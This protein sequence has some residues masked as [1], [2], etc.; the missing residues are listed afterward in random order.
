MNFN[1]KS[2]MMVGTCVFALFTGV[3]VM[4]W[5]NNTE[6]M[7]DEQTRGQLYRDVFGDIRDTGDPFFRVKTRGQLYRD[8]FGDIRDTGDPFFR[9]KTRGQ[10]YR[11]V[12]GDIRDTGDVFF[13]IRTRGQLA[14]KLFTDEDFAKKAD[15]IA[16]QKAI[17][18]RNVDAM[19]NCAW[20]LK[21]LELMFGKKDK[22]TTSDMLF[23]AAAKLAVE[24]G[25]SA[26]LKQVIALAP[27]CKKFEEE[28]A[29]KSKTRGINKSVTAFPQLT[30]LPHKD[31]EK[32][33]KGLQP[34][35]QP[36]FGQYICA[37]FRGMSK[38]SADT[39]AMLVNEGRVTMNPQM[40]AMGALELSKYPYNSKLGIKFEP[41]Q[42][43]AE[44]VEL[45]VAQ[46]DKDA[47]NQIAALYGTA[48]FKNAEY[49]KYLQGE[50][51][52]LGENR[53]LKSGSAQ[54][55]PGDFS[56]MNFEKMIRTV[57]YEEAT[58]PMN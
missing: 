46:Q 56:P 53:G 20:D 27:E 9:V 18:A 22:T 52:M 42:I 36:A 57:Y 30:L 11:D 51:A 58:I 5:E 32:A 8:V 38:K 3:N 35:E 40:I 17:M 16:L 4:A 7:F 34:W 37:S 15:V 33:L 41:A 49:T 19:T 10:L 45:A 21:G 2:L 26:A 12:F 43:F 29:L 39:V 6:N 48:N 24:Q 47:L 50:L 31:W 55:K 25:N 14:K 13:R 44:A 54:C 28:L 1:L 23:A